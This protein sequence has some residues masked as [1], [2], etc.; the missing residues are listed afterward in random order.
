MSAGQWGPCRRVAEK[1]VA[2]RTVPWKCT[3]ARV[4]LL[5]R[6]K[7][8][9]RRIADPFPVFFDYRSRSGVV[10]LSTRLDFRIRRL[11]HVADDHAFVVAVADGLRLQMR[12][13]A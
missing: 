6:P 11:A 9:G 2:G 12:H 13:F 8:T 7:K 4:D 1:L 3:C 5:F 10:R